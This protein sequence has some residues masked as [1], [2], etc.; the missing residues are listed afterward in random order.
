MGCVSE[1]ADALREGH[2]LLKTGVRTETDRHTDRHTSENSI[3]VS[4]TPFRWRI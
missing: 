4:F 3:Y 2:T 1:M